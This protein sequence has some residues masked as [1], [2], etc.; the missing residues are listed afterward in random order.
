MGKIELTTEEIRVIEKQLNG[1]IE[2]WSATDEEQEAL[3]RVIDKADALMDDLNAYN[4]LGGDLIK[5]F[6]NKYKFQ[7]N[8]K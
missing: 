2:V 5:W 7:G 6:Y 4:E 3:M 8:C 1:E